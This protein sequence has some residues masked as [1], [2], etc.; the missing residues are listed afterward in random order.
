MIKEIDNDS[1][2]ADV[3]ALSSSM[4][5]ALAKSPAHF[6]DLYLSGEEKPAPSQAMI[7]G[8]TI[9]T[10]IL[11]PSYFDDRYIVI[12]EGLD[13]RSKEGKALWQELLN[14]GKQPMTKQDLQQAMAIAKSVL[15]HPI[16]RE[17]FQLNGMAEQ[18]IYWQDSKHGVMC[19]AKPDYMIAPCEQYPNGLIVDL[20]TTKD[21]AS[22][23]FCW[24]A[25]KLGYHISAAH[26]CAGFEAEFGTMPDFLFLAVESSRPYLSRYFQAAEDGFISDGFEL[27][28]TLIETYIEC[29]NTGEWY[30]YSEE[31]E[32]LYLP[33]NR[34]TE[35]EIEVSYVA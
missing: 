5:K 32:T 27:R 11:E 18:S 19:K 30:G 14:S 28:D 23:A 15:S 4:L 10:I 7:R 21:A 8:S 2:H 34:P 24:N 6:Y 29:Q 31:I 33:E 22:N 3:S 17:I 9:H 35:E 20:K 26:Y 25:K 1:Y 13:R 16:S 12:P